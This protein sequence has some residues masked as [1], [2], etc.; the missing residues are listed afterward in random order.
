MDE[1]HTFKYSIHPG[2][3]KMNYD[4]WDLYRWP[5]MKKD[6]AEYVNKCLTCSKIKAEHQKPSGLLQL[7]KSA[8]FLPIHEDCKMEKLARIYINEIKALGTKLDISM[9]YHPQTD[10]QSERTIQTLED[11][12]R[13]CVLDF[14]GSWDTHLPLTTE[15]IMQIKER[16]KM[17]HDRQKSYADKRRKPLEFEVGDRVLLKIVDRVCPVAYRLRLPQELSCVHDTFHVSNLKKCLPDS[18]LQVSLEEIRIDDKLY[19]MEEPVEIVETSQ[20][21]EAKLD[22]DCQVF[23]NFETE[24][25]AI[26]F[27]DITTNTAL[28][29]ESKRLHG[30]YDDENSFFYKIISVNNLKTDSENDNEKVNMPSFPSPEPEVSYFNDLDFFK[31]FENEFPA[32]VYNDA[33]TSKSDL[34][35]EPTISPCHIDEFDLKD[36]TSLSEC[37]EEEQMFYTYNE[38]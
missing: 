26:V 6:I 17:V 16:F 20:E 15:K 30:R 37:D 2:A 21:I 4:L 1:A 12:L 31:D 9:T 23:T 28:S 18:D 29:C 34:L 10:G 13:A 14:G 27:D 7:T 24:F 3:D 33:L 19:F 35:T 11:M 36:E 32:V 5:G 8:Q 25:P 22:S 38:Y